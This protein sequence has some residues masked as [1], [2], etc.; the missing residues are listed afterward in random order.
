MMKRLCLAALGLTLLLGCSNS[1]E[2]VN[3]ATPAPSPAV[4]AAATP[5][6][7]SPAPLNLTYR[8]IKSYPHDP[9]AFIQ[10]LIVRDG[11]FY[12][13]TGLNGKSSLRKVDISTGAV[14]KKV[15]V[16]DKYFAEGLDEM[17]GKLYQLTWQANVGFIYDKN[18]FE[19][20]GEFH[21]DGEG[22]GL[23]DDGTDLI[24]SDGTNNIRFLDPK[25]FEVKRTIAVFDGLT[26]LKNLNE[27]EY[28]D[29]IIYANVW[30]TNSIV[31][32]DPKD[33]R[34]IAWIDMT[35]ILPESERTNADVLNGIAYDAAKKKLYIT[36]KLWPKV[37]E[38]ELIKE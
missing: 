14:L 27:L 33:G 10:G 12:E 11:V 6:T 5:Q 17:G 38:V 3:G 7:A 22:W 8:V 16:P 29:G 21:Y 37:Y 18:T 30:Q 4:K 36:G 13:S 23:T 25:T 19:K 20:V 2:V 15:S 24:L 32:I 35:G 31:Q 1:S 34:I 28:I 26:P 9:K